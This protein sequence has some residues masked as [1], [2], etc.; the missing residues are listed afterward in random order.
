MAKDLKRAF[1][2]RVLQ[3]RKARGWSQEVLDQHSG[4]HWTYIGQVERGERNLTLL[5]IQKIAKGFKIEMVDLFKG[6]G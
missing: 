5:S 6:L 1:G 3:L 4:L 2:Q